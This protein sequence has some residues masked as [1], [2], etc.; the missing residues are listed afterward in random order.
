MKMRE[1][2]LAETYMP[3]PV[4]FLRSQFGRRIDVGQGECA[5]VDRPGVELA[6]TLGSCV[7][8]LLHDPAGRRGGMTHIHR[9]VDRGPLGGA[10]VVA[11]IETL[12][13]KLMHLGVRRS[14]MI[15]RI[16]GG[17][18]VLGRG[19]NVGGSIVDV[20]LDYLR[21]EGVPLAQQ[22]L[23]GVRAR[24]LLWQPTTGAMRVTYPGAAHVADRGTAPAP[25]ARRGCDV[26]IFRSRTRT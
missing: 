4:R 22:D 8:V 19:P 7:A 18:H 14:D 3:D 15:G 11:E 21:A 16:V 5:V 17:A 26:E 9:C 2:A 24:R 10:A 25:P 13:N 1:M 23:G 12:V 20:C 6:A